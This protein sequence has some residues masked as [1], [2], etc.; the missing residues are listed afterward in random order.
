MF[1][2]VP[3]NDTLRTLILGDKSELCGSHWSPFGD[4]LGC[5]RQGQVPRLPYSSKVFFNNGVLVKLRQE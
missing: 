1:E 4:L 5:G 2:G 3:G